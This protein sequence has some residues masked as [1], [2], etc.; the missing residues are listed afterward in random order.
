MPKIVQEMA[1]EFPEHVAMLRHLNE[2]DGHF[3]RISTAY[4]EIGLLQEDETE[5]GE[6]TDRTRFEQLRL[7]RAALRQEILDLLRQPETV[8]DILP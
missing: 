1:K 5:D 8:E 6:S 2:T 4:I 7:H 3:H